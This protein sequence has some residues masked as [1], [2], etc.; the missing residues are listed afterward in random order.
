MFSESME[1]IWEMFMEFVGTGWLHWIMAVLL[2]TICFFKE[3]YVRGKIIY[4]TLFLLL[5]FFN[6]VFYGTLGVRFMSGMY[7]RI[8]WLVPIGISIAYG[9]VKIMELIKNAYIKPIFFLVII[10][11]VV[12]GGKPMFSQDNYIP[13]SNLYQL[14][15]VTIDVADALMEDMGEID[16]RRVTVPDELVTTM[17]QYTTRIELL[18]GRNAYGYINEISDEEQIV[19]EEMIKD[20]PDVEIISNTCLSQNIEYIVFNSIYHKNYKRIEDYSY[21]FL[22]NVDGYDIFKRKRES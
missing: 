17:R 4:P 5:I 9:T 13:A 12:L 15:Q 7:W 21:E 3:Q 22:K 16:V 8:L 14:P 6:P 18:Y 19:H 2:M 10:S 11:L 1:L 20:N